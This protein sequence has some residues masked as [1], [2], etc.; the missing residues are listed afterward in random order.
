MRGAQHLTLSTANFSA[1]DARRVT[2]L[3]IRLGGVRYAATALG[4]GDDTLLAARGQGRMLVKTR[5][6][7]LAALDRVEAAA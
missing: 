2:C 4:I 7:I 1:A 6:R 3:V 5:D